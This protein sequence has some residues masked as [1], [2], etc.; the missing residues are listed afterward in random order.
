VLNDEMDGVPCR[1]RKA[2]SRIADEGNGS[3]DRVR[4]TLRM[5]VYRHSV[6]LGVKPLDTH[7]R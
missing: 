2:H 1:H 4:D 5:P 6:R 3:P 7:D